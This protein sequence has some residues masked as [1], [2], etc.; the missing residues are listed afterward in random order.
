MPGMSHSGIFGLLA[1]STL[2]LGATPAPADNFP[3]PTPERW[4]WLKGTVWYVPHAN[5]PA[6]ATTA[7]RDP[8]VPLRDQTVY[9][10]EGYEYGYYWGFARVQILTPS[11]PVE[12][13]PDSPPTCMRMAASVTPEGS[14]NVAFTPID[15]RGGPVTGIGI[16]R[17][18]DGAWAM[19]LQMTTGSAA[20]VTHWAYMRACPQRGRCELPAIASTAQRFVRACQSSK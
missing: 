9:T 13:P 11:D 16:M 5:L 1:I 3:A 8:V 14:L 17:F 6:I 7:D 10:I 15:G 12:V 18:R 19:E 20:Q 2:A 4:A